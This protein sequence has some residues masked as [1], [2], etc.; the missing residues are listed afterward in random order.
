[1]WPKLGAYFGLPLAEP[2]H[3]SLASLMADKEQVM[4]SSLLRSASLPLLKV[5]F[6]WLVSVLCLSSPP[7][8]LTLRRRSPAAVISL[9]SIRAEKVQVPPLSV[10]PS[11]SSFRKVPHR[12]S[13]ALVPARPDE[14]AS[15]LPS[16]GQALAARAGTPHA[17]P[18]CE[19]PCGPAAPA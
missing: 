10:P 1:M 2:Q 12:P 7:P 4:P 19:E 16:S 18:F 6:L 3:I 9:T 11:P 17:F 5:H 13:C 15:L 14:V 8:I